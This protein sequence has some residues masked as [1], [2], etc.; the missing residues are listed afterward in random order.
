MLICD[1]AHR[2]AGILDQQESSGFKLVHSQIL[3]RKRL[4]QTATPRIYTERSKTVVRKNQSEKESARNIVDM[5][6]VKVYGPEF[7][8]LSFSKALE[9]MPERMCDYRIVVMLMGRH[10]GNEGVEN[11]VEIAEI[12]DRD[13]RNKK[14]NSTIGARLA[15]LVKTLHGGAEIVSIDGQT[16]QGTGQYVAD[17]SNC[18]V[19]CNTVIRS[20]WVRDTLNNKEVNKWGFKQALSEQQRSESTNSLSNIPIQAEHLDAKSRSFDRFVELD[21]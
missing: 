11:A 13:S 17:I 15:A 9:L 7:H 21:S 18:I 4:Y 2:T 1:E 5:S 10:H 3:A 6:D 20:R 14:T 8:S 16:A 19:Y 12:E